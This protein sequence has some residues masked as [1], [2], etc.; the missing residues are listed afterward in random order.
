MELKIALV[1][2]EDSFN[3][4]H[5]IILEEAGFSREIHSFLN[6]IEFIDF[7]VSNNLDNNLILAFLDINMPK[8]NAWGVLDQLAQ[9]E[10]KAK[11][12]IFM[13]S[14]SIDLIDRDRSLKNIFVHDY[15]EKPITET[16][17]NQLFEKYKSFLID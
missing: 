4:Y 14:S 8:M 10:L 7:V 9:L 3:F 1:D 6:G 11:V 15:V 17:V 13:V 5:Q 16:F 12:H 2:D